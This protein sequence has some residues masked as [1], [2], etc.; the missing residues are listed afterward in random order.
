MNVTICL[1]FRFI[2]K[3]F[4][5]TCPAKSLVSGQI[6]RKQEIEAL[7]LRNIQV[8]S[9]TLSCVS[10]PRLINPKIF[11]HC[12]IT[13]VSFSLRN[14]APKILPQVKIFPFLK[15]N[16]SGFFSLSN[17]I[18][19]IQQLIEPLGCKVFSKGEQLHLKLLECCQI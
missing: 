17:Y 12:W 5:Q 7:F 18:M 4:L 3:Q 1:S 15:A 8:S 13:S 9:D 2:S 6:R 14:L 10:R 16:G 11:H 19:F